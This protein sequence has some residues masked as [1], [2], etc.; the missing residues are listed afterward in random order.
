MRPPAESVA[1]ARTARDRA[2]YMSV[3]DPIKLL[4]EAADAIEEQAAEI[5]RLADMA[6]AKIARLH[7]ETRT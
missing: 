7:R 2:R 6:D 1:L 5:A 3:I 4:E